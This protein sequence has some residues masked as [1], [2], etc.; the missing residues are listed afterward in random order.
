[1]RHEFKT[2]KSLLNQ[3]ISPQNLILGLDSLNV[4]ASL[5][6]DPPQ[7]LA[8]LAHV[9]CCKDDD[10]MHRLHQ[11][12]QRNSITSYLLPDWSCSPYS[13]MSV[14]SSI[15]AQ[16][17]NWLYH[18]QNAQKGK[19]FLTHFK[20]LAQKTVPFDFISQN[21][22]LIQTSENF[23]ET[24]F[25]K[26]RSLG[27]K[28]V[29]L[30]EDPGQFSNKGGIVDVFSP[31]EKLPL[32]IELFG[33]EIESLH[34]FSSESQRRVELAKSYSVIPAKETPLNE[35]NQ[36]QVIKYIVTQQPVMSDE[37]ESLVHSVR[38]L[39][40]FDG[41]SFLI[42]AFHTKLESPLDHFCQDVAIW[43]PNLEMQKQD[44]D[45]FF[46]QLHQEKSSSQNLLQTSVENLYETRFEKLL[47][48]NSFDLST[49]EIENLENTEKLNRI[50]YRTSE[51]SDF[52]A[53][54]KNAY[55]KKENAIELIKNQIQDWISQSYEIHMGS[56]SEIGQSKIKQLIEACEDDAPKGH[57]HCHTKDAYQTLKCDLDH[58][59]FLKYSDIFGRSFQKTNTSDS[60][61]YISKLEAIKFGDLSEGD[62]VVHVDH[63]VG[64]FCGLKSMDVGGTA[65]DFI[66]LSYQDKDKLYLPVY[67]LN[68]IKKYAGPK[69]SEFLH[70]LGGAHWE[71]TKVK[72]K[73]QLQDM[74][75]ELLKMYALRSKATRPPYTPN[76]DELEKF[77]N[78]FLFDETEDQIKSI[79]S[80]YKDLASEKPMDRLICGDVGFGKTEVAMRAAF[81]VLS[82][83]K[84][85]AVL[86]P[87]TV[88]SFQHLRSFEKRIGSWGY[89]V[90]GLNRFVSPKETKSTLAGINGGTVDL[91]IGTHRIL[92]QDVKFK[93]LGLL[94]V[95]EEQKFGVKHKE[96]IKMFKEG[97]DTLTLSATPIPRTLNMGLLGLK[98]LSLIS[99]P[100]VDRHPI[101][102]FLTK[103]NKTVMKQ[104]IE[105]EV[106]RGGQIYFIHNRV[107][108]IHHL[109]EE[110]SELLPDVRM[111]LG[112]GQMPEDHLEK[113]MIQFFNHEIDMLV[114]TTIVE[115]GMDVSKANTIIIDQAQNFGLSQLYQLRGRVGRSHEKAF[116]YLMIPPNRNL[117]KEALEK[118]KT[119][120]DNSKL[121]SGVK[122][123]HYDLEMRGAGNLLGREQSGQGHMVGYELYMELLEE[124][125][126][127]MKGEPVQ[128]FEPD[129][130]IP[131]P[132]L[133]PSS[134]I[135][136]IRIRLTYYNQ[137]SKIDEASEILDIEDELRDQFGKLPEE[138]LNLL[139][140]MELKCH[141]R[142]KKI[143][144]I[145]AGPKNL[146]LR[147]ATD[148]P[149]TNKRIVELI[150]K[151]S[152]KYKLSKDGRLIIKHKELK[153]DQIL[154][155]VEAI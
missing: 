17:L 136:D 124:T 22:F 79:N 154:K 11:E 91:A 110:L 148:T 114:S 68:L 62:F 141:C 151:Q 43:A 37:R 23:N 45:Y 15:E 66:E 16:R 36:S 147:F 145:K 126:G 140:L 90:K 92:S 58:C 133:I 52:K 149:I 7:S 111:G 71:K 47:G 142:H 4:I 83:G 33:D 101:K 80:I 96:K 81:S 28:E 72:V 63:G 19:I 77:E 20:A 112:H 10:E 116:C 29:S 25:S 32:R 40:D 98:D 150:S 146:S 48:T 127:E 122:V 139:R 9:F 95:D 70:K 41:Q 74:T 102:T 14:K 42:D 88:L 75:S 143:Q 144:E 78:Q 108:S 26:L 38:S 107:Q 94:I 135:A 119:L 34:L 64:E 87:T 130:H 60:K 128:K 113:V 117:D 3:K 73:K 99:T 35:L 100:P 30:V 46:K 31:S 97:V 61:A 18:A 132:A 134:W 5:L 153:W 39:N 6:Q 59:L 76:L 106:K 137:L 67:K 104:A 89:N 54:I 93:N 27:Y 121:G 129:I 125:L 13:G 12:L 115:S 21:Q 105:Q 123:A 103:K 8:D 44:L 155:E 57:F 49:V 131:L 55:L 69:K 56:S 50:K 65:Q 51:L 86:A 109:F 2:L 84:Q 85:V 53:R 1:M 24:T 152:Q 138:S 82:S 118:L 120:Q